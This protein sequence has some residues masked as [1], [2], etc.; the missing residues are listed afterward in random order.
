VEWVEWVPQRAQ[1]PAVV[2]ETEPC[3]F[4]QRDAAM[5][6]ETMGMMRN[7][8]RLLYK[9]LFENLSKTPYRELVPDPRDAQKSVVRDLVLG[10]SPNVVWIQRD[11]ER[12]EVRSI[13]SAL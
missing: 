6:T 4:P 5:Q 2:L 11:S 1:R 12:P 10:E 7:L 3:V 13:L 8:R 9:T